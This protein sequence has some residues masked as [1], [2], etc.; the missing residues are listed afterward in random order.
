MSPRQN[1]I[2]EVDFRRPSKFNREHLRRIEHSHDT[3]CQSASSRLSAELRTE[4]QVEVMGTD[5]LPYSVVM[6]DEVPRQAF[7][8]ILGTAVSVLYVRRRQLG[9]PELG[10]LPRR[11]R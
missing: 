6:A 10:L 8:T 9:H 3:F 4:F 7:V 11:V 5:Q 1:R 2:R